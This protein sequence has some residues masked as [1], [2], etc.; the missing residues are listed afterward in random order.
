MKTLREYLDDGEIAQDKLLTPQGLSPIHLRGDPDI[1]MYNVVYNKFLKFY[2]TD[3]MRADHFGNL[4]YQF[5]VGGNKKPL[6]DYYIGLMSI[7]HMLGQEQE[8]LV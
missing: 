4:L 6:K 1:G 8:E 5:L 7:N 3:K 2:G